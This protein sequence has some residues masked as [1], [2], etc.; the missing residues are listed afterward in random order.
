MS[1]HRGRMVLVEPE[2]PSYGFYYVAERVLH[3]ERSSYQDIL[4]VD[5]ARHGRMLFLDGI[6]MLTSTTHHVYHEA[7]AHVPLYLH[8]EPRRVLVLGG[9][10]GGVVTEVVKHAS[11]THV[12]WVELDG[13]VVTAG[14]EFFP[15]FAPAFRDPRVHLRVG[16]GAAF[17][18]ETDARYDVCIIDSTDPG[19]D[20]DRIALPLVEPEFFGALGRILAPQGVGMQIVSHPYFE[21]PVF[22]TVAGR[23]VKAWPFF[24]LALAPTP[25]YVSGAWGLGLFANHE[26]DPRTPRPCDLAELRYYNTDIHR[27]LFALPNDVHRQLAELRA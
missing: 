24:A 1:D 4:V 10:D 16:D 19:P 14:R 22:D 13:A 17:V 26:L 8:P 27:A 25:F 15:E 3:Q 21:K 23:M 7:M 2:D 11:V 18:R 5:T 12:D 9:G 6:I 20:P